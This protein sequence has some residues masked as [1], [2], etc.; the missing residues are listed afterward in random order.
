MGIAFNERGVGAFNIAYDLDFSKA[1]HDFFPNDSQLHFSH[2]ITHSAMDT[3][4]K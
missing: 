4:A 1:F 3:K 2:A